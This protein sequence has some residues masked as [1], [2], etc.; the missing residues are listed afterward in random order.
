M[1]VRLVA[2]DRDDIPSG[3]AA[4]IN[5]AGTGSVYAQ[6]WVVFGPVLPVVVI[7]TAALAS[8]CSFYR[9][10][11]YYLT[12]R[13]ASG[14][15]ATIIDPLGTKL[16]TGLGTT[17]RRVPPFIGWWLFSG[18]M[19][20]GVILATLAIEVLNPVDGSNVVI[21]LLALALL[22]SVNLVSQSALSGVVFIERAGSNRC[23]TLVRQRFWVSLGRMALVWLICAG[24]LAGLFFLLVL[25]GLALAGPQ[26]LFTIGTAMATVLVW[27]TMFLALVL[28]VAVTLVT[29]A[30]LRIYDNPAT[31][32]RRLT[33]EM[34]H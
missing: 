22:V 10:A 29:Y 8:T 3:L 13:R 33:A 34:S 16:G 12:P 17:R 26:T 21:S 7:F 14:Q 15:P 5:P 27:V 30:E 28:G 4:T 24:Y 18:L 9:G 1:A 11:A 19:A 32:T 31:T 6:A 23:F 20:F 25:L 2:L